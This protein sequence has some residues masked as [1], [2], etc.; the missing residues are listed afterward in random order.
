MK[1]RIYIIISILLVSGIVFGG[2]YLYQKAVATA[3]NNAVTMIQNGSYMCF[4]Y[5]AF[6]IHC[7][8]R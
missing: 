1:K 8:H 4:F 5:L 2:I 7:L 6:Y 3:Y